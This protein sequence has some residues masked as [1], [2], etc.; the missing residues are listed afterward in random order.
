M[1]SFTDLIP[2]FNPY[3]QQLPVEAM[4]TVGMEK[5]K[6][7]DEGLQKIQSQI[8]NIAG[9]NVMRPIDKQYLQSKLNELGS[10]LRGVAAGDF[11]NFQLVNSVGGM[12]NQISK[13]PFVIAAVK[14]SAID[15]KN[16]QIMEDERKN[17]KL[18]P[19]NEF[20]YSKQRNKYIQSGLKDANGNPIVFSGS[21][22]PFF[23]VFKFTKE[24]FDAIKPDGYSYDQVYVTNADG[25]IKTDGRGKPVY[26]PTMSRLEKEGRFP[27]KVKQTIQQIFSDP[28]VSQ[29]LNITGE[30]NY[31]NLSPEQ[32][33]E[34]AEMQKQSLLEGLNDM[35]ADLNLEKNTGKDVQDK[36][37][38]VNLQIEN[39]TNRYDEYKKVALENPDV[40]RGI[41]YKDDVSARYTTMFS[42]V[43]TKNQV[44]DNPGWKANFDLMK[45]ANVSARFRE[46]MDFNYE[47]EKWDRGY[48]ML[49]LEMKGQKKFGIGETGTVQDFQPTDPSVYVAQFEQSY[50]NAAD[51][52]SSSADSMIFS[53]ALNTPK[54]QNEIAKLVSG[55]MSREQAMNTIIANSARANNEDVDQ[56]RNRW[57]QRSIEKINQMDPV[58]LQQ[59]PMLQGVYNTFGAAKQDFMNLD[60]TKKQIE[61]RLDKNLLK[62][63]DA[64]EMGKK[65]NNVQI[66]IEG[67]PVTVTGEDLWNAALY[68]KGNQSSLGFLNSPALREQAKVAE[69]KLRQTGKGFLLDFALERAIVPEG[70]PPLTTAMR[71][72]KG[73]A[74]T[75]FGDKIT[76]Q[77]G[78]VVQLNNIYK[79][80]DDEVLMGAAEAKANALKSSGFSVSPN[81]RMDILTGDGETDRA[82]VNFIGNTAGNYGTNK[83]NL[84]ADFNGETI[85]TI[86][87]DKNNFKPFELKTSR[88]DA[89]GEVFPELVF[90]NSAG[91]RAAGMSITGEEAGKLGVNINTL[92]ESPAIR[93]V[94]TRINASPIRSTSF[95]D[96][97]DV[98]TYIQGDVLFEK[99]NMPN[100]AGLPY[101]VKANIQEVDGLYYNIIYVNDGISKPKTR[102]LP[103]VR[104][105]GEAISKLQATPPQLINA[106]LNDK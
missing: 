55:G 80:L 33:F 84:S 1:A 15:Q 19:D 74:R 10:N 56:F 3:I 77:V 30:Y 59:D 86:L 44:L 42:D 81:L 12:V 99:S 104:T 6:R 32:L 93:N 45:E 85:N 13:D 28:R 53:L 8:E 100:L 101:D 62:S 51:R 58:K 102:P 22:S 24:T 36:I 18:S 71:G 91:K 23:D 14:S 83:Q 76:N 61:S 52:Y 38:N 54:N 27:E 16:L 9:L 47:K 95:G 103:P 79:S 75:M 94:T 31:R 7:Y 49:E 90:Y 97:R 68:A 72:I 34:R 5:Q 66:T 25:S 41:M 48:K 4:V 89:T 87:A 11:S 70:V 65:L 92:Y 106:I 37:D 46:Q 78:L 57:L 17:G 39:L 82:L 88:N 2:Q 64:A 69:A 98:S 26:S 96:P 29:Q 21:Y 63:L 20:N 105:V 60:N 40:V 43:K 73:V 50:A 67:R 35:L